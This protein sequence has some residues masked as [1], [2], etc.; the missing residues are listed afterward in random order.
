MF[1]ESWYSVPIGK[2]GIA[3]PDATVSQGRVP[4]A[5]QLPLPLEGIR[6]SHSRH[7]HALHHISAMCVYCDHV[8][9]L[10][11]HLVLREVTL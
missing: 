3:D 8:H 11:S 10:L 7:D 6:R 2:A 9:H 4:D 1:G 5:S